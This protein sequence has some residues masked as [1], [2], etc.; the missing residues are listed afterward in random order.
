LVATIQ[1]AANPC[2][3]QTS[4]SHPGCGLYPTPL[5]PCSPPPPHRG[6]V[7]G[8]SA[9]PY[10]RS[11]FTATPSCTPRHLTSP[12][13]GSESRPAVQDSSAAL[14]AT[15]SRAPRGSAPPP[16]GRGLGARPAGTGHT[17]LRQLPATQ[18][19]RLG[20]NSP[21][22]ADVVR[23]GTFLKPSLPVEISSTADFLALYDRCVSSGLKTRISLSNTS[24][25]QEVT[26]T[27]HFPSSLASAPRRRRHPRRRGQAVSAAATT[28]TSS[29]PIISA[30]PSTRPEHPSPTL[31]VPELS[32]HK[33]PPIPSPPPAK[34]TRKAVKRRCEVELLRGDGMEDDFYVPPPLLMPPSACSPPPPSPTPT[35]SPIA[36]LSPLLADPPQ[37]HSVVPARTPDHSAPA[38]APSAISPCTGSEH[39][40]RSDNHL[41]T[42]F[43]AAIGGPCRTIAHANIAD[44]LR[45]APSAS[46]A[47][48]LCVLDGP[49]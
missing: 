25:V 11:S 21:S 28:R 45:T 24:G 37:S 20:S 1:F 23:N 26:I 49:R 48:G 27:C 14:P 44:H 47:G 42:V 10:G 6:G 4:P 32:P 18:N 3:E 12:R 8:S 31:P 19:T 36:E 2:R 43:R 5:L 40:P 16:T 39:H 38:L 34:R 15:P 33:S 7:G 30:L 29:P 46:V 35:E 9:D 13:L 41:W 22:W 17:A